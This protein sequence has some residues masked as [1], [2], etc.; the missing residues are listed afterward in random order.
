MNCI[1][2][3]LDLV[4]ELYYPK[5]NRARGESF[6]M[7][8]EDLQKAE[9]IYPP[10]KLELLAFK[11]AVADKFKDYLYGQQFTVLKDNNPLTYVLT[12]SSIALGKPTLMQM[13]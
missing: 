11:W 13:V 8:V 2:M 1:P 7:P 12:T 3:H 5:N 4:W 9:K 6:A 10:H